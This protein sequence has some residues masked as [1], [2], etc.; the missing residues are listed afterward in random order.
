MRKII[1]LMLFLLSGGIYLWYSF[2]TNGYF[3]YHMAQFIGYIFYWVSALFIV[4]LFT[5]A[6][7]KIKYKIWLLFTAIYV[8][9]SILVAYTTGD[10]TDAII[11][12]DGK[13]LTLIF[14]CIYF[15][16]SAIYFIFQF[17]RKNESNN[18]S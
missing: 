14:I 10:G 11:N 6:L 17:Q 7:N 1:S 8:L 12:L 16:I 3:D 15:F 9:I 4:S 2:Y 13:L 18:I 5:Y